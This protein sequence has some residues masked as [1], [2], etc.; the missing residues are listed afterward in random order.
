MNIEF[1]REEAQFLY[2]NLGNMNVAV[3][4]PDAE[5]VLALS[6]SCLTKFSAGLLAE[7]EP[8]KKDADKG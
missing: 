2:N 4:S 3:A 8:K 1:T 6:R 5:K 7:A